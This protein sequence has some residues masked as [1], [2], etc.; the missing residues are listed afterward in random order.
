MNGTT[1]KITF[2][3]FETT[4]TTHNIAESMVRFVM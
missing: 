4:E 3:I 1:V 2:M